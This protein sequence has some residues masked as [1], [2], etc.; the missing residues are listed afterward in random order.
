MKKYPLA[1]LFFLLL[2]FHIFTI[3]VGAEPKTLHEGFYK[4]T[5]LNLSHGVHT[6]QNTSTSDYAF[7]AI[8]DSNQVTR[9]YMRLDPQSDKYILIPLES[10]F[11]I[12]V[13]GKSSI[14]IN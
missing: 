9:Q 4:A 3:P 8:F 1:F 5:D 7:I 6:V 14:I 10:E 12:I 13:S 11:E 2:I